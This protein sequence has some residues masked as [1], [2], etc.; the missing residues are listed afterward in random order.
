VVSWCCRRHLRADPAIALLARYAAP[1]RLLGGLSPTW[2][3]A[4]RGRDLL[5]ELASVLRL[6]RDWVESPPGWPG[7]HSPGYPRR[8]PAR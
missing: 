7:R 8:R 1:P 3:F 4:D 6:A 5:R 2:E